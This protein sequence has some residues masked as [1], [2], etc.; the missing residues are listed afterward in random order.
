MNIKHVYLRLLKDYQYWVQLIENFL[1]YYQ[2]ELELSTVTA[3]NTVLMNR[4]SL[5]EHP[6]NV[7]NKDHDGFG[8]FKGVI[9][10]SL[11]NGQPFEV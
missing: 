9:L 5:R 6:M 11:A 7:M 3:S 4:E 8:L 10:L 1:K 2:N